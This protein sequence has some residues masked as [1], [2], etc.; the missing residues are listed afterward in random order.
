MKPHPMTPQEKQAAY[1]RWYLSE[2][3]KGLDDIEAGRVITNDEAE[4]EMD[5][6]MKNLLDKYGKAA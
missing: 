4:R 5:A 3:Q 6:H 2:V 1:D